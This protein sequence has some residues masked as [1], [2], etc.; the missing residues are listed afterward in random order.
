MKTATLIQG[1]TKDYRSLRSWALSFADLSSMD[2]QITLRNK[3]HDM[4]LSAGSSYNALEKHCRDYW[5]S[6]S[7]VAGNTTSQDN[8][9]TFYMQLLSTLPSQPEG[10][11]LTSVRKWLADKITESS[12][13]L[14]SVDNT[15]DTLLKYAKVIGLPHSL[16]TDKD[17]PAVHPTSWAEVRYPREQVNALSNG[18]KQS[19]CD[20]CDC[21]VCE[22]RERGGNDFCICRFNSTFDLARTKF[23]DRTKAYIIKMR[24]Y[25]KDHQDV[26]TLKGVKFERPSMNAL[27]TM[28]DLVNNTDE[29]TSWLT[30]LEDETMMCLHCESD[31][32]DGM[33]SVTPKQAYR[34]IQRSALAQSLAGTRPLSN[35]ST[36]SHSGGDAASRSSGIVRVKGVDTPIPNATPPIPKMHGT[37]SPVP[38]SSLDGAV[39]RLTTVRDMML[40]S[41]HKVLNASLKD[42]LQ[43]VRDYNGAPGCGTSYRVSGCL[44]QSRTTVSFLRPCNARCHHSQVAG[45]VGEV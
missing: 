23:S 36:V 42:N 3:L 29:F 22:S 17:A 35:V 39:G 32:I 34:H 4:K 26:S 7:H 44:L 19:V 15:I 25:H 30:A 43:A 11:H 2:S 33:A 37:I 6:W 18:V 13:I 14:A 45:H 27:I 31:L 10:A 40:R 41:S 38:M 21:Y 8:L 12:S 16:A 1:K 5:S 9:A 24:A 20:F 28:D